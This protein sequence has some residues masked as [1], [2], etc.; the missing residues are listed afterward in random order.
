MDRR[1]DE[2]SARSWRTTTTSPASSKNAA[3][4]KPSRVVTASIRKG[5]Q[6][7]LFP[8]QAGPKLHDGASPKRRRP[9][10]VQ[11]GFP[12]AHYYPRRD[13][14]S[15]RDN[16]RPRAPILVR[17]LRILKRGRSQ[18]RISSIQRNLIRCCPKKAQRPRRYRVA[19]TIVR[20]AW[21]LRCDVAHGRRRLREIQ[22]FCR[23]L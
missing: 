14:P 16:A 4:L 8:A 20:Q 12:L 19:A 5:A 15:G 3:N 23:L 2:P 9:H 17:Q 22:V 7:T 21:T 6:F 11:H 10:G 1:L 13:W 18:S